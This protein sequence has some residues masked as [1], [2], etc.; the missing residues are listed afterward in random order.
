[1]NSLIIP[2][3]RNAESIDRLLAAAA[4]MHVALNGEF[5][6]VFVVDGSPDLSWAMLR[7]RLPA[8][9]FRSQLIA[10]SRNFGSF[11]AIRVGLQHARG[12]YLAVMAA[13]LQEPPSLALEFF[14]TLAAGEVD[15]VVGTRR[16][17]DDPWLTRM[18]SAGFWGMYR[19]FVMPEIPSGGV[20]VFGCNRVFAAQLLAMHESRTSLV[21]QIFWLGYRRQVVDYD[22]QPRLEGESAWGVRR[23]LAYLF[24]SLFAFSDLPIRF[25]VGVGA[26]SLM[27]ALIIAGVA[28]VARLSGYIEVPGY[29]AT[30]IAILGFGGFNALGL[31]IVGS[32]AWRAYENTKQRPLAIPMQ[33]LD[34]SPMED[35]GGIV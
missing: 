29:A 16:S 24:D 25:L 1:M 30:L 31:G 27:V 21:G 22:R 8:Q 26:A 3:Y 9:A 18:F 6:A 12:E 4:E 14:H 33:V 11:A 19:K 5:E 7:E 17:R 34:I 2:V 15:V 35:H 13:D 20:D 28:V 10:L 32:Y 23:K